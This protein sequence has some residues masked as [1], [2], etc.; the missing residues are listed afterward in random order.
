MGQIRR[1]WPGVEIWLRGDCG[2]QRQ[3]L[4]AAVFILLSQAWMAVVSALTPLQQEAFKLLGVKSHPARPAELL[5]AG[6]PET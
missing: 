5:A 3:L 6:G 4:C 2:G 1:R